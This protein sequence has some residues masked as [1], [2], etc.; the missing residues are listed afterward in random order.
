MNAQDCSP[1]PRANEQINK[2]KGVKHNV[3]YKHINFENCKHATV[4]IAPMIWT[5]DIE[6]IYIAQSP[7]DTSRQ[8]D[9]YHHWNPNWAFGYLV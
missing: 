5:P 2:A 6:K 9:R 7:Q 3:I 1:L 4:I 8:K